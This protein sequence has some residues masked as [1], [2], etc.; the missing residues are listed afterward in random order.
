MKGDCKYMSVVSYTFLAFL[1]IVILFYYLVP[2]KLQ[3]VVLL[4]ASVCFYAFAGIQYL[5][6]VLLTAVAVYFLALSMQKNLDEQTRRIDG[7]GRKEARVIKNEMK[8]K[9]KRVLQLALLVVIGVLFVFKAS[10]FCID[11]VNRLLGLM[12]LAEIPDWNLIAPL[13]ISF[14]SFMMI[15]Y[16]VDIYNGKATAER[17]FFKYLTYVLYFPHVTQGPIAKF[18]QVAPQIFSAHRFSYDTVTQGSWLILWGYFKKLVIADR[19]SAFVTEVFGHSGDYK[20]TIFIFAGVMYSIQI[21]CDFSGCMDIVRGTSECFDIHLGENFERPYFSQT[22][23]EFWR[24]WHM[25]LGAFFR[26]YVFY[27]VSTSSVFLKLNTFARKYLGNDW[28]RNIA[29][30]LPILCVWFLTGFW[31]GANWNYICW[32]LFHGGLICLS[33]IF[34]QPLELLTQRLNIKRD[35]ISWSIFRM[36]RTFALCVV[37]RI[38]FMGKGVRSAYHML[39]SSVQDADVFYNIEQIGLTHNEWL[40]VMVSCTVLLLVSVAQEIRVQSGNTETIRQW[41]ARQNLWLRWLVLIG[42]ILCIM[43]YGVYGSGV[44]ATF[45]YEQF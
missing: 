45:I 43:V 44:G 41:L 6:V 22:L 25:S 9:R 31:H 33:T 15:S 13:G 16:L 39:R 11:N 27:P 35:C 32:G 36:L 10:G 3:W 1:A 7:L 38:I 28:G 40:I 5:A 20:G 19:L 34:E 26:E 24:R 29:S 8:Q 17:N 23:P 12:S 21:Y 37:G 30:C 14:Y 2:K 42:G 4:A 18:D